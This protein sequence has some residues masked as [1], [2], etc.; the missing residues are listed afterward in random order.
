[1]QDNEVNAIEEHLDA[2]PA[3]Q[4]LRLELTEIKVAARELPLHSPP[5]AVWAKIADVLEAELPASERRTREEF[6]T[7]TWWDRWKERHFRLSFPQLV[8][9][10]A[11]AMALVLFG[12]FGTSG[13][14]TK[15]GELNLTDAQSALLPDENEIKADLSRRLVDINRQ[16]AAWEP[17]VRAAFEQRLTKIEQSLDDCR[18]GLRRNPNDQA[19]QQALRSLY[20][21]KGQL[22]DEFERQ[23]R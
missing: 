3:C 19:R 4:N 12:I 14:K 1:M 6:P 16:K 9:A 21:Q 11:L 13:S 20:N 23:K 15:P 22:L 10:G 18:Q 17:Q 5:Q 2:C 8:G 7:E